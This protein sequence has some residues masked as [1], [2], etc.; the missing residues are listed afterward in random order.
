MVTKTIQTE[1][2]K[3]YFLSHYFKKAINQNTQFKEDGCS[4][5]MKNTNW[6]ET[7]FFSTLTEV[8]RNIKNTGKSL[9]T[10]QQPRWEKN[11][12]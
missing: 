10:A 9:L 8:K 11:Q 1:V 4:R 3:Y 5:K 12:R 6:G 2:N 7:Y